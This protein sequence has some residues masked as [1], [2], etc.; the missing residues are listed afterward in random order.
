MSAA[1][2]THTGPDSSSMTNQ[3]HPDISLSLGTNTSFSTPPHPLPGGD[4]FNLRVPLNSSR[5]TSATNV[6]SLPVATPSPPIGIA[7]LSN[8]LPVRKRGED[9]TSPLSSRLSNLVLAGRQKADDGRYSD[10]VEDVGEG[11]MDVLGTP[12]DKRWGETVADADPRG[13]RGA[14]A[15]GGGNAARSGTGPVN[16]GATLTLR[17]QE[18]HIDNLKKENFAIKLRVHF[19]EERLAQLAPDHMD[20]A[21]KQ[22]ISLKIEVHQ[23]GME[24]KKLKKLVLELERELER[25]QRGASASS[26]NRER[27]LEERLEEREREL[28]ELRDA[29]R[30]Q[31]RRLSENYG[32]EDQAELLQE[33]EARNTDLEEQLENARGLLEENMEEIEQLRDMVE[34][35]VSPVSDLGPSTGPSDRERDRFQKRVE[36]LEVENEDLRAR[37]QEHADILA[38]REE[39]KEDLID[40]NDALKLEVEDL[41]RKC[42][43]DFAERSQSRAAILEEREEREAVEEDLNTLKDRLAAAM[44]ELQ[45]KEDELELR[46]KEIDEMVKEHQRIVKVVEDEWR[47]E[48]EEARV[49]VEELKDVLAERESESRDLRMNISELEAN[50]NDLHNKFEALLVQLESEMDKKEVQIESLN[51]TI[52][53]LG[54]QIYVIE[55]ENDRLKEDLEHARDEGTAECERL[56]AMC[57]GF[58]EKIAG[59]KSQLQQISEAYETS[60]QEVDEHRARQEELARH[61]EEL[62]RSLESER[63]RRE[64]VENDL[65]SADRTHE[66]ELRQERRAVEAKESALQNALA[67]LARSQLLLSQREEDLEA[68]QN[69]LN[70]IDQESKRLGESHTT[71]RFSLQLEVE[72]MARDLERVQDELARARKDVEEKENKSRE[73]E[74]TIDK[75][76]AENRGLASQLALQT[77]A[78]LNVSEKLD[79][80]QATLKAVE[81][82]LASAKARVHELEGRLAKDQ[83]ELLGAE[84]QY[85]DQLTERNTLL[86]TIY[87]YMD[88]ILGV[89]KTPKKGSQ[90]ETKPF[91]NF[92]VFHDNLITR[93]KALSQ[94][95]LDFDKR[96]KQTEV[97]FTERLTDMRKQL[98][99][100]WKQIDKFEASVRAYAEMKSQWRRKFSTKEGEIEALKTTNVELTTQLATYKRPAVGD[101]M[102][103]RS[104]STRAANAERRLNNAQNQLL[105][106]EERISTMNQR[107][108]VADSKWEARVKEYETRLKAAEERVKRERQ[109][110]KER[111]AELEVNIKSLQRQLENAYKRNQQ[112]NELVAPGAISPATR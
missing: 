61:I 67:D 65:S 11:A 7:S 95:Q 107:N 35:Q 8:A 22:N 100:R 70:T 91:T 29:S 12:G 14:N 24:M 79:S 98:D 4:R 108:V 50:T 1:L 88:K 33:V 105:V 89:D 30:I 62:V 40:E 112:L 77:Q 59:L 16:K 86:L 43:A 69:A 34:K 99:S 28:R 80:V 38:Q 39:E 64:Q 13:K 52:Q 36:S 31:R 2:A 71:A 26:S 84:T 25:L 41:Q 56:E 45:Q 23:R 63:K 66:L 53:K 55:D 81:H 51:E 103:L 46:N 48:V 37:L 58:K 104:L 102:E 82:D 20:A 90:A 111:V 75:L 15:V 49:Q 5:G 92:S 54:Q 19:L 6:S 96:I 101:S 87:Q 83:R 27:E 109:G 68:V 74:A 106:T 60:S 85:R 94:I 10:L 42:E 76:H 17:D 3:T 47:G 32:A 9:S 93:L 18:K 57:A 73:K 110:S 72:R 78:K 97:R 21:L 44:I